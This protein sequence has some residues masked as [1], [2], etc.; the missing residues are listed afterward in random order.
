MFQNYNLGHGNPGDDLKPAALVSL[1]VVDRLDSNGHEATHSR[2][3]ESA[4]LV[5]QMEV[6]KYVLGAGTSS[7]LEEVK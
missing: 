3:K 6:N 7:R 1:V 5:C 4:A 2:K